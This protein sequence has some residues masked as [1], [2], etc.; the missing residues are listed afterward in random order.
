MISLLSE[1]RKFNNFKSNKPLVIAHRGDSSNFPENS[2]ASM[3]NAVDLKV[4]MLET[5]IRLTKDKKLVIFHDEKLD[6]IT[7]GNGLII[8]YTLSE[9]KE[10]NLGSDQNDNHKILSLEEFIEAFKDTKINIDI[11]DSCIDVIEILV[12]CIE[13]YNLYNNI[14]VSSF[15]DHQ[16]KRFRK[17]LPNVKTGASPK[18]I[19]K[20]LIFMKFGL[21][22]LIN[23]K[24]YCFQVPMTHNSNQIVTPRFIRLAHK[25]NISV[26]VWTI[27]EEDLMKY[28]IDVDADGIFTD[29]P[30]VLIDILN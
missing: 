3:N 4:D 30:K 18:E 13:K 15:H 16:I 10:F 20:F 26:M 19:K 22:F 7:N 27:N 12:S 23:P 2:F 9:L 24:Y 21:L 29:R 11:K 1:N 25:K 8:D 28:L 5:D 17:V 6:R 14:I